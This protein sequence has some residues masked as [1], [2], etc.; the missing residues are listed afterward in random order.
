[1]LCFHEIFGLLNSF[2]ALLLFTQTTA[3]Q[4]LSSAVWTIFGINQSMA[5]TRNV[6]DWILDLIFGRCSNMLLLFIV[7]LQKLYSRC[8]AQRS[9]WL[10]FQRH[11][12]LKLIAGNWCHS[13][14]S[15]KIKKKKMRKTMLV[16]VVLLL[17]CGEI[18]FV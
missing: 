18:Y 13:L 11:I 1:M 8:F 15:K 4:K 14:L 16:D 3:T 9:W 2:C 12:I 17:N 7:L 10:Y 6:T 5:Y